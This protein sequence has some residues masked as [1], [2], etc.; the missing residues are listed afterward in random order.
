M[1]SQLNNGNRGNSAADRGWWASLLLRRGD[2]LLPR[3]ALY[4]RELARRPRGWRRQLRRKLAVTVSGAALLLALAG[5][6]APATA[7]PDAPAAIIQV[8]NGE[9]A[10]V[11]NGK[12]SLIEAIIN[13]RTTKVN[14]LR[15][16]C[17]AG[18]LTGPDTVSL[19]TNGEF[20]LTAPHNEQFGPTGLPV[21]TNAMT[22]EGNGSTIRRSDVSGTPSFRIMVVDPGVSLT[23]RNTGINNGQ[24]FDGSWGGGGILS[25]GTLEVVDSLISNN[26]AYYTGGGIHAAGSTTITGSAIIG[27]DLRGDRNDGGGI[28]IGPDAQAT[29]TGSLILDNVVGAYHGADGG[30]IDVEGQAVIANCTISGNINGGGESSGHGGGISVGQNG[31]ATIIGS[32]I[33]DNEVYPY[34][35]AFSYSWHY[36]LGGGLSNHGQTVIAN[37]TI[38]GNRASV[39]GGVSNT[40]YGDLTIA[41]STISGNVAK[42]ITGDIDG[43][44]YELAGYGGGIFSGLDYGQDNCPSTKLQGTIVAGNTA[45][46]DESGEQIH[47]DDEVMYEQ[48]CSASFTVNAFNVFGQAGDVG[49]DG[50]NPGA[51]DVVP[52]AGLEA[53]LAPLADNGGPTPTHALPPGSPALDLAPSASCVAAPV[54]GI[55]QRGEPRNQN[56]AGGVTANECDAGSFE[57]AGQPTFLPFLISPAASGSVGGVAFTPADILKFD[58]ATGWSLYFDASDVGVSKNLT[59]LEMLDDG[60]ILMSFAANQST[61]GGVFTPQDV[62]RFV[63]TSIGP[64]T[65]GSFQWE[66]NGSDYGLTTSNEKIDALGIIGDGRLAISTV[67]AAAV[68]LPSGASLKAQDE[69]ALGH[70]RATHEWS[71]YFDGTVIPG[72]VAEDLNALWIDRATCTSAWSTPST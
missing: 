51:T 2:K 16:D 8:V 33:T 68:P 32:T 43:V 30:G 64:N 55:D 65:A 11:T 60:R 70:S 17:T 47:Y 61:P 48:I 6:I 27:N 28:Y 7:E 37:T 23:L 50:L 1:D 46:E 19:P 3:F 31:E 56:G 20:V 69:D 22:I 45:A 34:Y 44:P 52:A 5:P 14:Q 49:L 4:Y 13:A 24:V 66:M 59:A 26:S 40:V 35:E 10:D 42:V 57:L 63:P 15:P 72:L 29:I 21:I 25:L 53:I 62:A 38:S 12:C 18:N 39:G 58:P 41:H 67:G 36:G 9:V 71:A 54:N